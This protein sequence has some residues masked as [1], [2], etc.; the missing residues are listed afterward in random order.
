MELTPY[1]LYETA[2]RLCRVYMERMLGDDAWSMQVSFPP[3]QGF[4]L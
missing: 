1:R 3:F 4:P 2:A